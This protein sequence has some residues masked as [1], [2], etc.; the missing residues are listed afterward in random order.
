MLAGNGANTPG[1]SGTCSLS[2]LIPG[3]CMAGRQVRAICFRRLIHRAI[4]AVSGSR[5]PGQADRSVAGRTLVCPAP[6]AA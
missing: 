6:I 5:E 3:L 1:Y 4:A 2:G